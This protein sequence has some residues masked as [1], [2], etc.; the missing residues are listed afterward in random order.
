MLASARTAAD[1]PEVSL[2]PRIAVYAV[3]VVC[4]I[5][6]V[7]QAAPAPPA[8]SKASDGGAQY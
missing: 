6:V 3:S 8:V 5:V 1:G 7:R 4:L 2:A